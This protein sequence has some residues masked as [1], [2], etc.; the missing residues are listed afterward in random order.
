MR[1]FFDWL[2]GP[3]QVGWLKTALFSGIIGF[4]IAYLTNPSTFNSPDSR[5]NKWYLIALG[6]PIQYIIRRWYQKRYM[7]EFEAMRRLHNIGTIIREMERRR[8]EDVWECAS[9]GRHLAY[10]DEEC[11]RCGSTMRRSRIDL[12]TGR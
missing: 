7:P 1:R 11:P 9:C 5:P 4:S 3:D 10:I 8:D 12:E 2:L 6:Y